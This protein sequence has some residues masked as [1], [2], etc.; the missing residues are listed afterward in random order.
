[1]QPQAPS[2]ALSRKRKQGHGEGWTPAAHYG[3]CGQSCPCCRFA[4][5]VAEA[6]ER[7]AWFGAWC[8]ECDASASSSKR[9]R[10]SPGAG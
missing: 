3:G 2:A 4:V 8:A 1:M 7:S 10:V 5:N 6:T 9:R